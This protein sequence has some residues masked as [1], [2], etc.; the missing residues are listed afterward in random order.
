[1]LVCLA[2]WL[3]RPLLLLPRTARLLLMQLPLPLPH[4]LWLLAR[5]CWQHMPCRH[6]LQPLRLFRQQQRHGWFHTL[7][8][9]RQLQAQP[10]GK[11]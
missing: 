6:R 7:P 4:L 11:P 3:P 10:V 5:C 2:G 1:M 8:R 9:P